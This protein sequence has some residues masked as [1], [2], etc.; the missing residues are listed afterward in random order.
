MPKLNNTY[1]NKINLSREILQLP[2]PPL[3]HHHQQQHQQIKMENNFNENINCIIDEEI[4]NSIDL[5]SSPSIK[6]EDDGEEEYVLDEN[7]N[8]NFQKGEPG[9]KKIA[10]KSLA[11]D[12]SIPIS[13]GLAVA[14]TTNANCIQEFT[15]DLK[16]KR[17]RAI[18]CGE[19]GKRKRKYTKAKRRNTIGWKPDYSDDE[20][21]NDDDEDYVDYQ[22]DGETIGINEEEEEE[23]EEEE[24]EEHVSLGKARQV[25]QNN[26]R[27]H[28]RRWTESDDDKVAFL[29]EYGH[30]KWHEVTEFINGRHTPQAVQMRYLRS[31]KRRNDQ[32]TSEETAKLERLVTED[33]ETR[34]KRLSTAMGPAF[35]P[36]RIQKIFLQ[37]CGMGAYLDSQKTW[38]KEEISRLVDEAGGDFDSFEVPIRSDELPQR[39]REHMADKY[40]KTYEE[41]VGMYVGGDPADVVIRE[42]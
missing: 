33:Y 42:C 18:T 31:L 1:I 37:Q 27:S 15:P 23:G 38:T 39:A 34:F 9:I 32:L 3:Q 25:T 19:P 35:T 10:R 24:E 29:R 16:V 41:L 36:V 2:T 28:A 5:R 17:R 6:N 20:N 12:A 13:F 40:S 4:S 14:A 26:S 11:I 21:N 22:E 7:N 30:L 8:G